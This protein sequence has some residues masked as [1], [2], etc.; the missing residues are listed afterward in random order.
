VDVFSKGGEENVVRRGW[1][2]GQC[3]VEGREKHEG[4]CPCGGGKGDEIVE[5]E[6]GIKCKETGNV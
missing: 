4:F 3:G 2:I 6:R 5:E 1:A